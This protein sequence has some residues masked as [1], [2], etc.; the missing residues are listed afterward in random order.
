MV[1][2]LP[3]STA[4]IRS[5]P[6]AVKQISMR[7]ARKPSRSLF[8]CVFLV[9]VAADFILA[10]H[11]LPNSD[12]VQ[13][14]TEMLAIR[15]GNLTLHHWVL[16]TDDY[17]FTDLVPMLAGSLLIGR[18]V[19]LIFLVPFVIFVVMLTTSISIVRDNCRT[20]DGRL[21]GSYAI[22]LLF[23]VPYTLL[24]NFFFW[25]DFHV[26]TIA[27]CLIAIR[28]VAPAFSDKPFRTRRLFPFMT[29]V[30]VASFSD[31][32]ADVVLSEPIVLLTVTRSWSYGVFR[33]REWLVA[34]S[35]VV[36]ALCGAGALH[37]LVRTGIAFSIHPSASLDFV[38]DA[39]AAIRDGYA[40]L[41]A[42]QVLF[43]ARARLMTG[44]PLHELIAGSRLLTA[45]A[46][47]ALCSLVLWQLPRSRNSATAQLLVAGALCMTV[48]AVLGSTFAAAISV[49]N[50]FPGA[51]VRFGVPI[52]VF[53][54]VAAALE[55]GDHVTWLR[56]PWLLATIV[57]LVSIH[58]AGAAIATI[59]AA[60][61]PAGIHAGPDAELARWLLKRHYTYGVGDYWDTQLVEAETGG[62]VKADPVMNFGGRLHLSPWL[63]DTSRFGPDNPPQFAI[64]RP[65]GVFRVDLASIRA[66]Y[67]AP[68]GVTLVANQFSIVDLKSSIEAH[69]NSAF[70]PTK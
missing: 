45:L 2:L 13:S 50:D 9:C 21:A 53:L 14:F 31:P 44:L 18:C 16:A 39:G 65:H 6:F 27:L 48:S 3:I 32:L 8:P 51:A 63:T 66:T 36:G 22:L 23:G 70:S 59:R 17:I 47:T 49:G 20:Q 38:P 52:F 54:C 67:G 28:T 68:V 25:T 30:C 24:Y 69:R 26:A 1:P 11:Q 60:K 58:V 40:I 15:S 29:L 5:A 4:T 62:A 57:C 7:I 33:A 42:E 56:S 46:V 35:G 10:R 12:S 64:I 43:G 61:A 37:L 55:I 34:A 41:G 19:Q